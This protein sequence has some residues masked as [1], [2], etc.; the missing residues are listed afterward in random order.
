MALTGRAALVALAGAVAVLL[1]PLD[2]VTVL[3]LLAA[4]IVGVGVDL[5]L[6]ASPRAIS[7]T[8]GGDTSTR[9]GETAEV[10]VTLG[11]G[12]GRTARGWARDACPPSAGATPR[13]QRIVV[14]PGGQRR[15]VTPLRP[16][17]RG[18]RRAANVTLRLTGPLG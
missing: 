15:V 13:V 14:P 2:G 9:V 16:T 6:A 11:N 17:R 4:L 7:V 12:T 18:E 3:L 1:V 5:A 10:V 8:R